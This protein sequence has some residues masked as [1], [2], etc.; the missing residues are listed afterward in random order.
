MTSTAHS[1]HRR[2]KIELNDTSSIPIRPSLER[3]DLCNPD[4]SSY[5]E[6]KDPSGAAPGGINL[7]NVVG[8]L[9]KGLR[10]FFQTKSPAGGLN[11]P[12][13]RI[14]SYH[15]TYS[16]PG[17][18]SLFQPVCKSPAS[19]CKHSYLLLARGKLQRFMGFTVLLVLPC[20][21]QQAGGTAAE[22]LI[23]ASC[24]W[25]LGLSNCT[26][27]NEYACASWRLGYTVPITVLVR[28]STDFH[29]YSKEQETTLP[30]RNYG[31]FIS[32]IFSRDSVP[33]RMR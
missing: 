26:V 25:F 23:H 1:H 32:N 3:P 7:S 10:K 29:N 17:C 13:T 20:Q 24:A 9:P 31:L 30:R 8:S 11:Q 19:P 14:R 16:V 18:L 5:I 12:Q 15:D 2:Y 28:L 21:S 33:S 22:L 4:I 6:N 27:P